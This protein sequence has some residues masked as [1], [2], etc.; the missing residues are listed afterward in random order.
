[1]NTTHR[2]FRTGF[3]K[4]LIYL[5][6]MLHVPCHYAARPSCFRNPLDYCR[7]LCRALRLLLVFRHNKVVRVFNGYKLHLYLPAYPSPAFFR[8][9]DAKLLQQP[10][11]ATTI[12]FAMT[13]ACSYHCQHCYQRNDDAHELDETAMIATAQDVRDAGVAMF[14]IEGGEPFLRYPRLL[15]LVQALD[16]RCETWINTTGAHV[17]PGQLE[18]LQQAGV[19]GLMVSIHSPDRATHDQFT[20][21]PGS[22]DT[23]CRIVRQARSLGLAVALNSVLSEAEATTGGLDRLMTLAKELGA[24]F[25]QLIHPKRAG[26]WISH[27]E[28]MQSGSGIIGKLQQEHL[29]YNSRKMQSYPALAAQVFEEAPSVLGCTAGAVD[30]YY[31]GANGDVQPCEFLNLSFGNVNQESFEVI[32][33]RMRSYFK[34]PCSTWLCCAQA[35]AIQALITKHGITQLPVPWPITQE[36]V[37]TWDRG[38]PTPIYQKLG[39]YK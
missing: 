36:L 33:A 12:V 28:G 37:E 5:R 9:I 23:A 31:V 13:K 4:L 15:K 22:F 34:T 10:P 38:Q 7:F 27:T 19:F 21:V 18:E 6:I 11:G 24:D 26:L 8:A 35:D 14:D 29:R 17:Q 20:G 16:D 25:V 32:Y 1:M 3:G 39:I 2:H 30:R